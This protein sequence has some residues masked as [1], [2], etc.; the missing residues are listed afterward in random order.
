MF[1]FAT[2][3]GNK[4]N[5]KKLPKSLLLFEKPERK[6]TSDKNKVAY[7]LSLGPGVA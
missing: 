3:A 7:I 5:R 2:V 6:P 1:V 4:G